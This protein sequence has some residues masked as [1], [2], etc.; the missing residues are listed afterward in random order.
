MPLSWNEN[1]S[2]AVSGSKHYKLWKAFYFLN[3]VVGI[4][5]LVLEIEIYRKTIIDFY[6]PLIVILVAGTVAFIFNKRH[7]Q[8][9]YS[10]RGIFF[11]LLQNIIWW[12][13]I[14][15]YL[16]M[17]TNYYF[18]NKGITN[19]KLPIKYKS[20]LPGGRGHRNERQPLIAIDYFG[21]EKDLVF[22]FSQTGKV[23]QANSAILKTR[24][25]FLGFDVLDHY[26]VLVK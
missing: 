19:H 2:K 23:K 4:F 11:P 25:G 8:K 22:R 21:F 24:K 3:A 5:F 14:S 20:S 7:Y 9:V 13:F 16:F 15:C 17:A 18:A 6:V 10:L 26:D 12:G 1:K